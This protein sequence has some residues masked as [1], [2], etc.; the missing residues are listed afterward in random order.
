M[1]IIQSIALIAILSLILPVL[2][3]SQISPAQAQKILEI[4]KQKNRVPS[5]L[6][7]F[8]ASDMA[9]LRKIV[10][11]R[12]NFISENEKN[13]DNIVDQANTYLEAEKEILRK[14]P[15]FIYGWPSERTPAQVELTNQR[16][17]VK[18]DIKAISASMQVNYEEL[19]KILGELISI[20]L[21]T[22]YY[23]KAIPK[24]EISIGNFNFD[25]KQS[26]R[27]RLLIM[28]IAPK[29]TNNMSMGKIKK[30]SAGGKNPEYYLSAEN[31][32]AW[33]VQ[34]AEMSSKYKNAPALVD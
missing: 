34:V 14:K 12:K 27:T 22:I 10:D 32:R 7:F 6:D 21:D 26:A 16:N 29:S 17:Y 5:G 11:L 1:K 4:V 2:G 15:I 24:N 8:E 33:Y 13:P 25:L 28:N 9:A 18:I 31:L 23:Y 20:E 30:K 3:Q 19:V